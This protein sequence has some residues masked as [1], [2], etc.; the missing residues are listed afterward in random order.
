MKTTE[1][2]AVIVML[3]AIAIMIATTVDP[4]LTMLV[5]LGF[6]SWCAIAGAVFAWLEIRAERRNHQ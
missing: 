1:L 2:V 5:T 3:C 6:V 4:Y